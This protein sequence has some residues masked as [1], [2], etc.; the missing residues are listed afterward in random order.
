MEGRSAATYLYRTTFTNTVRTAFERLERYGWRETLSDVEFDVAWMSKGWMRSVYPRVSGSLRWEQL[1]NHFPNFKELTRKDLLLKNLK[2]FRIESERLV[3]D[4]DAVRIEFFPETFVLPNQYHMFVERFKAEK[5]WLW[6]IKPS[7]ACQ[8]MGIFIVTSLSQV[9]EFSKPM[10]TP[11]GKVLHHVIQRYVER[12]FLIGGKKFDLRLYCLVTCYAPLTAFLFR[13]GFCRFSGSRYTLDPASLGD[14]FVHLT[15]HA[16]QKKAPDGST[17]EELTDLKWSI[18]NLRMF[19]VSKFGAERTN[20][21]FIDIEK[22]MEF[23]LRSVDRVMFNDYHCFELYGFDILV[24]E[25]LKPWIIEVNS[26]PSLTSSS[27]LDKELKEILVEETLAVTIYEK[28]KKK[29]AITDI[30][31]SSILRGFDVMIYEGKT[32]T[33]RP[34]MLGTLLRP[35]YDVKATKALFTNRS[36]DVIATTGGYTSGSSGTSAS[37]GTGKEGGTTSSGR[38]SASRRRPSKKP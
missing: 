37:S 31:L 20:Q 11:E 17:L 3:E 33:D 2:R 19:F 23:A 4:V 18:H 16:I 38:T 14:V 26:S 21:L 22:V 8:G 35:I 6:I 24:D 1:V 12:P 29:G 13:D 28:R 34:S 5:D 30:T 7:D 25:N 36:G 27:D 9:K 15:N 32:V 10:T